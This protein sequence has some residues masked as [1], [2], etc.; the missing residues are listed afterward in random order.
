MYTDARCFCDA[1]CGAVS[2]IIKYTAHEAASAGQLVKFGYH[3]VPPRALHVPEALK[4]YAQCAGQ[5]W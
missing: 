1:L 2:E 5:W 3:E 4:K